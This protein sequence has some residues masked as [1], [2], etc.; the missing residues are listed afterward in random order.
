MRACSGLPDDTEVV[1]HLN[2]NEKGDIEQLYYLVNP[3]RRSVFWLIDVGAELV[4][5]GARPVPDLTYISKVVSPFSH[6]G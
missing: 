6:Q 5:A 1:L 3:G 2:K 4:T